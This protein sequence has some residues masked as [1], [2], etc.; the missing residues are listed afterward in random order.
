MNSFVDFASLSKLSPEYLRDFIGFRF[1]YPKQH[2]TYP[3]YNIVKHSEELIDV[4]VAVAGFNTSELDVTTS[5]GTL[6]ITGKKED[7]SEHADEN[8]LHRG[9]SGRNFERKF[10]IDKHMIVEGAH[11]DNGILRISLK[12]VIPES[13]KFKRVSI[14]SKKQVLMEA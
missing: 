5:E 10:V 11:H 12:R 4:E 8:Y 2:N 3:P 6:T 1:D 14:N 9:I 13:E 7:K